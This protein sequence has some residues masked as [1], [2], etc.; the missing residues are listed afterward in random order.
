M[1]LN[2]I[3]DTIWYF[4]ELTTHSEVLWNVAPLAFVTVLV[5]F[6]FSLYK[7]EAPGWNSYLTNSVVLLFVSMN[8]FRYIYTLTPDRFYNFIDFPGKSLAGVALLFIGIALLKFNFEHL[9][10]EKFA[11]YLSSPLTVNLIAYVIILFVYSNLGLNWIVFLSLLTIVLV[12]YAAISS[13]KYPINKLH[14]YIEKE[15]KRERVKNVKEARFQVKELKQQLKTR[16]KE[17]QRIKTK[18]VKGEESLAKK[19]KKALKPERKTSKK[20]K[21]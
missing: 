20:K 17:L 18:E 8:L 5:V 7:E 10:P 13:F 14:N 3:I 6:Y 15:K 1:V 9:V 21:K 19:L 2:L 11:K 16:E 4:L 12:F